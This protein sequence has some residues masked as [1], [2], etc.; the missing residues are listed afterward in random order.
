[1]RFEKLAEGFIYDLDQSESKQVAAGPR[2]VVTNAGDLLC[3]FF[4]QKASGLNDF[5][6]MS[7]RSSDN[8]TSWTSCRSVWPGYRGRYSINCSISRSSQ[9]ELFLYGSRTPVAY[10]GEANWCEATQG[11]K[12]NEL[13][14]ARS[15][16]SGLTWSDP[17]VIPM[18]IPGSSEAPG[19]LCVL[20]SGRWIAPYS[21]Y[22]TF[23][24]ALKV[25]RNQVLAMYSD[26]RGKSWQHSAMLHF[27][28]INSNGAEAWVTE[29]SD[30]RLLG[31]SWHL[32][33]N[34][35]SDYPNAYALSSDGGTSWSSTR[36]TGIYGQSNA[37]AAF[38]DGSAL[39]IYNQRKTGQIG[40]WLALVKPTETDFG[41]EVNEIIWAAEKKTKSD[42]SSGGHSEWI[43]FSFGE[44]SVTLL[45]D[46]TLLVTLWCI[47]P[48]GS[49]IKYLKLRLG[50]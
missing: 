15:V 31:A 1:M 49:G 25:E 18:P 50:D 12:Q 14:Y 41:I 34:D 10:P 35:G 5:E 19:T 30:G 9:G 37:L 16:D 46:D 28:D 6:V 47:L 20:K 33:Q 13:V 40:V 22:N 29:L 44:P 24:P 23:D 7:A 36:S 17:Q 32:N 43:D 21:P 42:R 27:S 48:S 45:P 38:R 2:C 4:A 3:T 39:Y 11:L 26:D 8:G